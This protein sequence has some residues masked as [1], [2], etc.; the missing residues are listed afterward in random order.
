MLQNVLEQTLTITGNSYRIVGVLS[1]DHIEL[2]LA[3]AGFNSQVYLPWDF[4]SVSEQERKRWG[5]DDG[6]L[7]FVGKFKEQIFPL[8][9]ST[10]KPATD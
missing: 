3:G 6:G 4:N 10:N 8:F 5:N 1:K 9:Q 2:P 7:M